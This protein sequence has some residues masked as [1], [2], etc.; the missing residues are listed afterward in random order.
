MNELLLICLPLLLLF[1]LLSFFSASHRLFSRAGRFSEHFAQSRLF[2]RSR[3]W[4]MRNCGIIMVTLQWARDKCARKIF[5][6][7]RGTEWCLP[8]IRFHPPTPMSDDSTV[9]TAA[10]KGSAK[11]ERAE[12][13]SSP[14]SNCSLEPETVAVSRE[15]GQGRSG[16]S[17]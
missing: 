8:L 9:Q 2:I 5:P 1:P 17:G 11:V 4:V 12:D 7:P 14:G 16:R 3:S 6:H 15:V 10:G 13:F